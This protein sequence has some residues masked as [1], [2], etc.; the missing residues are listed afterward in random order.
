M[1]FSRLLVCLVLVAACAPTS[2]AKLSITGFEP[3]TLRLVSRQQVEFDLEFRDERGELVEPF[4]QQPLE[5]YLD[6]Y[7]PGNGSVPPVT[8]VRKVVAPGQHHV[9]LSV[10]RAEMSV[11]FDFSA[12]ACST[13]A[14][15]TAGPVTIVTDAPTEFIDAY[16][17][18]A[19]TL[20]PG[21]RRALRAMTWG[22][23][24]AFSNNVNAFPTLAPVTL[25]SS[26]P[27]VAA[28]EG[29]RVVAL[30]EGTSVVT[31]STVDSSGR[32]QQDFVRVEVVAGRV[33]PPAEG[34][35]RLFA[36]TTQDPT[37]GNRTRFPR[38]EAT[39]AVDA[40]GAPVALT[41]FGHD[42]WGESFAWAPTL[43]A[44]WTGSGFERL[45]VG[46]RY[47][48]V[49]QPQLTLDARDRA[50][51]AYVNAVDGAVDGERRPAWI[52]DLAPDA[53]D[54]N[55]RPLPLGEDPM[56][57]SGAGSRPRALAIA[58]RRPEGAWVALLLPPRAASE[59]CVTTVR[60]VEVALDSMRAVDVLELSSQSI[61][62]ECV[63]PLRLEPQRNSS[64]SVAIDA[65]RPGE[66]PDVALIA[67]ATLTQRL[68]EQDGTW[69]AEVLRTTTGERAAF[70]PREVAPGRFTR[71][72]WLETQPNQPDRTPF[73]LRV[74]QLEWTGV[75]RLPLD[76]E[77]RVDDPTGRLWGEL[78][79]T[80]GGPSVQDQRL[81]IG[82]AVIQGVASRHDRLYFYFWLNGEAV[83]GIA[84][85]PPQPTQ[86]TPEGEGR[87]FA[88]RP[89][90]AVHI[91]PSGRRYAF[92]VGGDVALAQG[93]DQPFV[94][95]RLP[96]VTGGVAA[97]THEHQGVTYLLKQDLS[98]LKVMAHD[99]GLDVAS[100]RD[101][102]L[103]GVH[104]ERAAAGAGLF[105]QSKTT[106]GTGRL[107]RHDLV[108]GVERELAI[109]GGVADARL[110]GAPDGVGLVSTVNVNELRVLRFD[111]AGVLE[112]DVVL[113][114][115]SASAGERLLLEQVLLEADGGV[116]LVTAEGA[117]LRVRHRNGP[118]LEEALVDVRGLDPIVPL[119]VVAIGPLARLSSGRLV[120]ALADR[121]FWGCE[122][123]RLAVSDGT[124]RDLVWRLAPHLR[125]RGSCHQ[126]VSLLHEE[127]GG[128]L[129]QIFDG[130]SFTA[131]QEVSDTTSPL[132]S[133][134]VLQ[135]VPLP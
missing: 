82:T 76:L 85:P 84:D 43:L 74:G 123:A 75:T 24:I 11:A 131:Q 53:V 94:D 20:V 37:G 33:G 50:W 61:N 46:L 88:E 130:A 102:S 127:A 100:V 132:F 83:L 35:H 107:F 5:R 16:D 70:P 93:P 67:G 63:D 80:A 104:L 41:W 87:I 97:W 129:V 135:R 68:Y 47:Q 108:S 54:L 30:A 6:L 113:P 49:E 2:S 103:P 21:E 72:V 57:L 29:E 120:L 32:T 96:A 9:V 38:A 117:R 122:R 52:A 119:D 31:F 28:I 81:L 13:C 45:P 59:G 90:A 12:R 51:V 79:Q 64:P 7:A 60:L 36:R 71:W 98:T 125:P 101:L 99:G 58:P 19:I 40:Q 77:G 25:S 78:R 39:L 116:S 4:E 105:V 110:L 22:K 69:N 23:A 42:W 111:P 44:R 15:V 92:R 118:V 10:N 56:D 26:R 86:A 73:A 55:Y 27:D 8:V 48:H 17:G 126:R 91:T 109:D 133:F 3:V 18:D 65:T 34:T 134:N 62:G 1:R 106:T 128:L 114:L 14:W 95:L 121:D 115:A 89:G 124:P 112:E 66:W